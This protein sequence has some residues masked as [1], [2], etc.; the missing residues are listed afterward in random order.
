[1]PNVNGLRRP[2]AVV[3]LGLAVVVVSMFVTARPASAHDSV[4]GEIVVAI[5]DPR[6][7]VTASVPFGE[8]GLE[9]TSGDGLIDADELAAQRD[10]VAATLV[11]TV[12]DHAALTVD[13]AP[14]KLEGAGVPS[15]SEHGLANDAD[16][17]DNVVLLVASAAHEGD[18]G[19]LDL[20][21]EF[22][23]PS[24][25]V[26]LSAD[27]VLINGQ[28]SNDDTIEFSLDGWSSA[29]SFFTL[30]IEHIIDGPDHL[31]FLLVLTLAATAGGVTASSTW[32]TVKLVTAFTVG[33]AISLCLAYFEVV[34]IPAS[35]VEPTISLSIV[36]AAILV[37]RGVEQ[38][39]RIW[40]AS[41]VGLVH[42]LGFASSLGSLGIAA[43][44]RVAAL[45]AFNIGID[46][47]QTL[48]VL[49]LVGLLW[50][51]YQLMDRRIEWARLAGAGICAAFGMFW[52]VTRLA[53]LAS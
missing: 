37:L 7:M 18:V 13:G 36:A 19:E 23:G 25:A 14:L 41:V 39:G 52:T 11:D 10:T 5:D 4:D 33:H 16:A 45:A 2:V 34:S 38:D 40:I 21:W 31:L 43:S 29:T 3:L 1:M 49:G 51:G 35:I 27:D 44:Q 46:V 42:G 9:D 6:I 22:G 28:L 20:D 48:V 15:I 32:L 30:G 53:E 8:L 24:R 26:V 50:I 12:R 47:A 17:S